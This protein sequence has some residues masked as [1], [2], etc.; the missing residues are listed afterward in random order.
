MFYSL[1]V[2]AERIARYLK[3]WHVAAFWT[4]FAFDVSGTL[5]MTK[6]ADGPFNLME[7][8]TLTGQ[9]ALWLMLAHAIWASYVVRKGSEKALSGFHRYSL[10]VWMIWLIP[11][12]GGMMMGMAG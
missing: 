1:G 8:H 11:Y 2:W 5:A 9:I 4:G 6:L 10:V 7:L 12:F 3:R